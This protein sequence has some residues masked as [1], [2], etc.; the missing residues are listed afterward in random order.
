MYLV[1]PENR[2]GGTLQT[3]TSTILNIPK[4]KIWPSVLPVEQIYLFKKKGNEVGKIPKR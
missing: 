2:A 3:A 4:K 1:L